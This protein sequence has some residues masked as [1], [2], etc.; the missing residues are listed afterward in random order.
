[1]LKHRRPNIQRKLNIFKIYGRS[2]GA[3]LAVLILSG[4]IITA[5]WLWQNSRPVSTTENYQTIV[6]PAGSSTKKIAQSLADENLIRSSWFFTMI[7]WQQG[8]NGQLQA[9]S[10]DLSPH[11]SPQQIAQTLTKGSNDLWITIQEGWRATQIGEYLAN[12]LPNFDIT[13]PEFETECLAYEGRLF[14]ETYLV[15]LEYNTTQ[16]CR[17]LREQFDK[18]WIDPAW[19]EA[20]NNSTYT[21]KELI[22]LASIL[23]REAKL[24]ADMK[25]VAGILYNRLELGMALQVDATLQYAKGYNQK[26]ESWWTPPTA[27]DKQLD[28]AYNTYQNTGLPPGPIA[29]PGA[30]ALEAALFPTKNN[31]LYYISNADGTDMHFAATYEQHQKNINRYLR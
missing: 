20:Q 6:I 26:T 17:L 13:A 19:Q 29:N 27:A 8:L 2:L 11:Q 3:A 4:G 24:P 14:P 23:E 22:S 5:F 10:F 30:N 31:Y 12:K 21:S 25:M 7:V 18:K 1:M 15:P 28:S 9:G 16:T